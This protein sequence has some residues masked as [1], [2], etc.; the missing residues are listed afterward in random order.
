[1]KLV[2]LAQNGRCKIQPL[3]DGESIPLADFKLEGKPDSDFNTGAV[4]TTAATAVLKSS[5]PDLNPIHR[6]FY[7]V[8]IHS[9]V[10]IGSGY[11]R[12]TQYTITYHMMIDPQQSLPRR[13]GNVHRRFSDF[14]WLHQRLV[15]RFRGTILP[16]LPEKRWTGNLDATFIE[17]R[18]QALEHFIVRTLV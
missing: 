9:P 2:G 17:V 18:R 6:P 10:V 1:M 7:R 5:K 3:L 8:T 12:Y 14:E 11:T 15:Q 4:T 13:T 16:P